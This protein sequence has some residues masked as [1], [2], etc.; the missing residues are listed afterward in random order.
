MAQLRPLEADLRGRFWHRWS[1]VLCGWR[2]FRSA[3]GVLLA[4]KELGLCPQR[5]C[6][7]AGPGVGVTSG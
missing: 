5:G 3:T 7:S 6:R 2:W 1:T 4:A